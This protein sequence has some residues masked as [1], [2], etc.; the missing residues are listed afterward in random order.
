MQ[1]EREAAGVGDIAKQMAEAE[2]ERA[3]VAEEEE[4]RKRAKR[5]AERRAREEEEERRLAEERAREEA[6]ATDDS[7]ELSCTSESKQRVI[8][9]DADAGLELELVP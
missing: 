8:C 7:L 4:A 5:E 6:F 2:A 3:R 9:V 1:K